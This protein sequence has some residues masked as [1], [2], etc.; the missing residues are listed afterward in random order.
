MPPPQLARNAPVINIL[1][2][3]QINLAIVLRNDRDL[4]ALD[5]L[6]CSV[7]HGL[8]LDEPL[9]GKARLNNR[10]AAVALA[11]RER[12]IF[13]ADQK[14]L[15]LQVGKHPLARFEAVEACVCASV[16]V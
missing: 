13:L 16:L 4:A 5:G 12:V 2:P 9:L 3:V 8:Y 14:S 1:H 11:D 6:D 10:T 15:F 7:G